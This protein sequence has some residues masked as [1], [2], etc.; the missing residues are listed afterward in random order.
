[1]AQGR[2]HRSERKARWARSRRPTRRGPEAAGGDRGGG[3]GGHGA[4][5]RGDRGA[6]AEAMNVGASRLPRTALG[7]RRVTWRGMR[8]RGPRAAPRVGGAHL[9]DAPGDR[10]PGGPATAAA[11]AAAAAA[12]AQLPPARATTG[13]RQGRQVLRGGPPRRQ[14][15]DAASSRSGSSTTNRAKAIVRSSASPRA[16]AGGARTFDVRL[17]KEEADPRRPGAHAGRAA[18]AA[19]RAPRGCGP[20]GARGES[21]RRRRRP[22]RT[23]KYCGRHGGRRPPR[24]ESGIC[25]SRRTPAATTRARPSTSRPR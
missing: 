22:D 5:A 8:R 18:A 12:D 1:M 23:A 24:R 4:S 19:G 16:P 3:G 15:A 6:F 9:A 7:G 13:L 11:A 10:A 20:R 14:I 2:Q 17:A 21:S 25:G